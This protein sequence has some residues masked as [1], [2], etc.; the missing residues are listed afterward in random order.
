MKCKTKQQSEKREGLPDSM[1][2]YIDPSAIYIQLECHCVSVVTSCAWQLWLYSLGDG[3][4]DGRAKEK[5]EEKKYIGWTREMITFIIWA[6]IP[7]A[8]CVFVCVCVCVCACVYIL[9]STSICISTSSI[10]VYVCTCGDGPARA[11][12]SD[13]RHTRNI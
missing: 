10:Y 11:F 12:H 4:T 8:L 5:K 2:V 7:L 13:A 3:R 6:P 9:L 1:K